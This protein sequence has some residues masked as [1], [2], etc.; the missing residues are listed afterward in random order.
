MQSMKINQTSSG[1]FVFV[2]NSNVY[3]NGELLPALPKK[4]NYS[5]LTQL[6]NRLFYNGYEY[7][8]N[9]EKWVRNL[10][11]VFVNIFY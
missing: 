9:K 3:V 5:H 6:N 1:Q 11:S 4:K 10:K 8:F 7:D 2:N